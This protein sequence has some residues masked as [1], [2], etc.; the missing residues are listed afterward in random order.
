MCV[1][2]I[3]RY[4]GLNIVQPIVIYRIYT[5]KTPRICTGGWVGRIGQVVDDNNVW[6]QAAAVYTKK[7]MLKIYND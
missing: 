4:I 5:F 7:I 3:H 1:R 6:C 2:I